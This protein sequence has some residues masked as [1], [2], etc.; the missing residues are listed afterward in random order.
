VNDLKILANA[1]GCRGISTM[2]VGLLLV[3]ATPAVFVL[4]M[5]LAGLL[6]LGRP[7]SPL[8]DQ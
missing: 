7:E 4:V 2:A 5:V 3:V 8:I 6:L 1:H